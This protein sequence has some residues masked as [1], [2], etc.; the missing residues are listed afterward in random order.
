MPAKISADGRIATYTDAAEFKAA[1]DAYNGQGPYPSYAGPGS[2]TDVLMGGPTAPGTVS[3]GYE[4]AGTAPQPFTPPQLRPIP[5]TEAFAPVQAPPPRPPTLGQGPGQDYADT[6]RRWAEARG[7]SGFTPP[8][9]AGPALRPPEARDKMAAPGPR[10]WEAEITRGP[11]EAPRLRLPTEI[12]YTGSASSI[13]GGYAGRRRDG[14]GFRQP[15]VSQGGR[16]HTMFLQS[17]TGLEEPRQATGRPL[18]RGFNVS[19]AR[20]VPTVGAEDGGQPTGPAVE[21]SDPGGP[22]PPVPTTGGGGPPMPTQNP[23]TG[24]QWVYDPW[25]KEWESVTDP[26]FQNPQRPPQR[27]PRTAAEEEED[28][29]QAAEARQRAATAGAL[30]PGQVALQDAQVRQIDS[31]IA[32]LQAKQQEAIRRGDREA[33]AAANE[34]A[35]KYKELQ[36]RGESGTADRA[37]KAELDYAESRRRDLDARLSVSKTSGYMETGAPTLDREKFVSDAE[38][39]NLIALANAGNQAALI[40]LK[41][42]EQAEGRRQ[43]D[44]G[45]ETRGREFERTQGLS[46]AQFEAQRRADPSS[47]FDKVYAA[48]GGQGA[49]GGGGSF[50]VPATGADTGRGGLQVFPQGAA[51]GAQ[52]DEGESRAQR[53]LNTQP[54]SYGEIRESGAE[55][56]GIAAVTGG[57]SPFTP[58]RYRPAGGMPVV[59]AQGYGQLTPTEQRV[60]DAQLRVTGNEPGDYHAY[61]RRLFGAPRRSGGGFSRPRVAARGL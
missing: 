61:R 26:S 18:P 42:I 2:G 14:S 46:E 23:G 1:F 5:G 39:Q 49:Q 34:L 17:A 4:G 44:V 35:L 50:R 45:Q 43:F 53:A 22:G 16:G 60:F 9:L 28:A 6:E 56:P 25:K 29:A 3:R 55:A 41:E 57:G 7:A 51:G 10:A 37:F 12:D 8:A 32:D 40:R 19:Y 15:A 13:F 21:I 30:L 48:R 20:A 54:L 58:P 47:I 52:A 24:R 11:W 27:A 38:R 36:Q 33:A 59:S 31:I